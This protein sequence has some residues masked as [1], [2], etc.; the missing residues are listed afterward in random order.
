MKISE[1]IHERV[2]NPDGNVHT[3]PDDGKHAENK[4]CWCHPELRD[5]FTSEGGKKHYVHNRAQ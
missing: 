3:M 1:V 2:I 4:N 5:D